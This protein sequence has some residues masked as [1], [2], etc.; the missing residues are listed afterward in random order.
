MN[1]TICE[2]RSNTDEYAFSNC[3]NLTFS[4]EKEMTGNRIVINW[5]R[6]NQTMDLNSNSAVSSGKR[7]PR[8]SCTFSSLQEADYKDKTKDSSGLYLHY[9]IHNYLSDILWLLVVMY[10]PFVLSYF[11]P[12]EF[13]VNGLR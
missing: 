10:L 6:D 8:L 1:L 3:L 5:S 13:I 12:T 7:S 9:L 11:C 2:A 4:E